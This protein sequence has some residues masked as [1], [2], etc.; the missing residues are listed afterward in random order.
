LTLVNGI[1][2]ATSARCLGWVQSNSLA[3][4]ASKKCFCTGS[5]S[6]LGRRRIYD[7]IHGSGAHDPRLHGNRG[8]VARGTGPRALTRRLERCTV[9][10]EMSPG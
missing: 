7:R 4:L 2:V 5:R 9:A 6:N 8:R 3:M 10:W 1:C